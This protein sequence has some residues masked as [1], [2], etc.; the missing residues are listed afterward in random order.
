MLERLPRPSPHNARLLMRI[1]RPPRRS[2]QDLPNLRLVPPL[3]TLEDRRVLR[4][5]GYYA[6]IIGEVHYQLTAGDEGFF[7]G[8]GDAVSGFEGADCGGEAGEAD[9][10]VEDDV[11][12][13]LRESL[14]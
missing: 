12:W 4:V 5:H 7:V 10:A 6:V 2:Q 8:E 3:K 9:D 13:R 11:A 14:G 1:E